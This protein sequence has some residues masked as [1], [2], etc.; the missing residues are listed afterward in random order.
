MLPVVIAPLLSADRPEALDR[1]VLV[2]VTSAGT[3][4]LSP[5]LKRRPN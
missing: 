5:K 4:S 2:E 3:H 1:A